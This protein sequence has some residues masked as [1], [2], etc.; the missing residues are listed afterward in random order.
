MADLIGSIH[1]Y[2]AWL[3]TLLGLLILRQLVIMWRAGH[4]REQ[5][6][7]GLEREAASGRAARSLV[8]ILLLVTIGAGVFTV[9]QVVAPAV[10]EEERQLAQE[11]PIVRTPRRFVLSTD[12]PS[13]SLN[14]A[15]PRLPRIVTAPPDTPAPEASTPG[16]A[17]CRNP[18]VDIVSPV[19]GAVLTGSTPIVAT[20]RFD[21]ES[22]RYFRLE[23]GS[24]DEPEIWHDVGDVRRAPLVGTAVH[25][26]SLE[27][28]APGIYTLRLSL[29]EPDGGVRDGNVCAVRVRVP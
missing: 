1:D 16:S 5:A 19:S 21:P 18:G 2:A 4:E 23:I 24:G 6:M 8:T 3:Y 13:V 10:P 9:A 25:T 22:G 14:T 12:T 7:F 29:I 28:L 11:A 17:L 20:V 27:G 15:T 26:L